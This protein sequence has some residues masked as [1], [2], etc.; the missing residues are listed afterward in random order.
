MGKSFNRLAGNN[1]GD[2]SK[3][4]SIWFYDPPT[5]LD[6]LANMTSTLSKFRQ[7]DFTTLAKGGAQVVFASMCALEKGFVMTKLG[8]KLAGDLVSNLVTGIGKKRIDYV[9]NL[10][11][12]FKD[13]EMEYNFYRQLD[14]RK[15]KVDGRWCQY[16]LVSGMNEIDDNPAAEIDTIYVVLAIE[17]GHA[18]NCGLKIA[19]RTASETEI[20]ANVDK[21]KHWEKRLF[22]MG[23]THHFYNELAGHAK[24]LSGVVSKSCDQSFGLNEGFTDLGWKVLRRLLDNSDGRRVLIDLKHLS[25]KAREEYYRFLETEHPNEKIPLLVSHGAVTGLKSP[26]EP[27]QENFT[28]SGRFLTD[29]INF[30]NDEIIRVGRSG[31]LFGIQF[32]E[33]RL[34]NAQ[35]VKD[36][37][38]NLNRRKMLFKKSRLIWNQIQHVAEVLDRDNQPAWEI[39]CIG[40]DNDGMV[41]PLNGY[42]TAEEMPL[43]DSNLEKHAYNFIN[44][45]EARNFKPFNKLSADEIVERFMRGNAWEFLKRNF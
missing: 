32:D 10:T 13:L 1:N 4:D 12:Y 31:G 39:Q 19:G 37:G 2:Q 18:L 23:L 9:Q 24:S 7:A 44:S 6:K 14:G 42:W 11:D 30:Y 35:E 17:G 3:V 5:V 40:S 28:N 43:L 25:V 27:I 29:D 26:R 21:V 8:T 20:L 45:P 36:S 34:G 41:N 15:V 33:R 22:Y 16:K 38:N